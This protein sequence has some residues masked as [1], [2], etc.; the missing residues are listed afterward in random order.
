MGLERLHSFQHLAPALAEAGYIGETFL[1][2]ED[3]AYPATGSGSPRMRLAM[4]LFCIS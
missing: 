3:A 2:C 4:M 1:R